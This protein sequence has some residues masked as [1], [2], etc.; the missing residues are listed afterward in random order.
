MAQGSFGDLWKGQEDR[1]HWGWITALSD[2]NHPEMRVLSYEYHRLGLDV[3]YQDAEKGRAQITKS[4]DRLR[5]AKQARPRSPLLSNFL[6]SKAE[7]LIN[8]YSK[9]GVKNRQ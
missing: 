3:M 9:A 2:E 5:A 6:D 4:L 8:I 1:N 7:E